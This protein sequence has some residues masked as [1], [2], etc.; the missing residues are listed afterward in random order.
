MKRL[1]IILSLLIPYFLSQAQVAADFDK[2]NVRLNLGA[3]VADTVATPYKLGELRIRPQDSLTYRYNGKALGQ[4]RWDYV[5]YGPNRSITPT[6]DQVL[7]RGNSSSVGITAGVSTFLGLSLPSLAIPGQVLTLVVNPNGSVTAQ[8]GGSGSGLS[9][10]NAL[11]PSAQFLAIGFS[12]ATS[13]QWL[14]VT[15]THT[16]NLPIGSTVDTGLVIPSQITSWN[17][18]FTFPTGGNSGEYVN[19]VGNLVAFPYVPDSGIF[20]VSGSGLVISG[21]WPNKVFTIS[22]GSGSGTVTSVA[23]TP[24]TSLLQISGSPI[25]GAGAFVLTLTTAGANTFWGNPTGSTATPIYMSATQATANLNLFTTS[26]Q[27]LVPLSGGGTTNFLRSDGT[28]SAPPGGGLQAVLSLSSTLNTTNTITNTGQILTIALGGT[29][30]LKVTG[31]LHDTTNTIGLVTFTGDSSFRVTTWPIAS[32]KVFQYVPADT[33]RRGLG[34]RGTNTIVLGNPN[35]FDSTVYLNAG[36]AQLF[37]LDSLFAGFYLK[38]LPEK[39][40]MLSTDSI[41]IEDNTGK[42]WKTPNASG[43]WTLSGTNLSPNSLSYNVGIGTATPTGT[44]QVVGNSILGQINGT[45]GASSITPV[46]TLTASQTAVSNGVNLA[47]IGIQSSLIIST[48]DSLINYTHFLFNNS[49]PSGYVAQLSDMV[50]AGATMGNVGAFTGINISDITVKSGGSAIGIASSISAG[51]NKHNLFI[52][53]TAEN[54]FTNLDIGSTT[55]YTSAAFSITSTTQAAL[56]P[57]MNTAQQN[58]IA[59]P[60]NGDIIYNTDSAAL[61]FYNGSAWRVIGTGAGNGCSKCYD[62]LAL[63][64]DSAVAFIK[65]NGN[66]DT[67]VFS[68]YLGGVGSGGGGSGSVTSVAFTAPTTLF[69]VTGS[70]ITSSGTI[71]ATLLNAAGNT[72]WGNPSG[73]TGAPSYMTATQATA[74]LNLFSSSLQ[75]LVPASGGGTTNFL[76]ADMTWAAP[77]GGGGGSQSLQQVITVSGTL[78]T[79]NTIT[80]TG[81]ILTLAMGGSGVLRLT[82]ISHDTTGT[83]GILLLASDSS[84]RLATWPIAANKILQYIAA[85]TF[86]RGL[87]VVGTNTIVLGNPKRFDSVV[88]LNDGGQVGFT[89]DS[90][91]KLKINLNPGSDATG[92]FYYRNASG[93]MARLPIGGTNQLLTIGSGLAAWATNITIG[94]SFTSNGASLSVDANTT[95]SPGS[96]GTANGQGIYLNAYNSLTN[97]DN[98]A[99][100]TSTGIAAIN[101]ISPTL[102]ATNTQVYGFV[103]GLHI[104]APILGTNVSVSSVPG[105]PLAIYA[106]GNSVFVGNITGISS[107]YV[108][109]GHFNSNTG[110]PAFATGAGSGGSASGSGGNDQAFT[111]VETT[112]ASPTANATIVTVTYNSPY[113]TGSVA[114]ISP[115]NAAT[116]LLSGASQVYI[117]STSANGF[118]LTS[119]SVPLVGLTAYKWYVITGGN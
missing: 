4:Q 10:L 18:K 11:T 27:G 83:A 92:D 118:V 23:L 28:W 73:S 53:G 49:N 14:D 74:G 6:L 61:T 48:N 55:A 46:L 69:T 7:N 43:Y 63:V 116:A 106:S 1:L 51:T 5:Y 29:G 36:N 56:L 65:Q 42:V 105:G 44:F 82:G 59:S 115:G 117:S 20:T 71:V 94:S 80:T 12:A 91:Y 102:N 99:A 104:T 78:I 25:T 2:V 33:F 76:R 13:P 77:P 17:G 45:P 84:H 57:R 100:N 85:D 30:V 112:G 86:R 54:S 103:A 52:T 37:V 58:A 60:I 97:T 68:G 109:A 21:N 111:L 110:N 89:L 19:G 119:G 70:P 34:V 3:P 108:S 107:G 22:A 32:A 67:L 96:S 113:P 47:M 41:L 98:S 62:S 24:P 50:F 88:Y 8:T 66:S 79:T 90:M 16:L 38:Q 26:L 93:Y 81:Q 15:A 72:Y 31:I 35:H 101:I 114:V 75:G 64:G 39:P 9:S 40:V 87:G 95:V